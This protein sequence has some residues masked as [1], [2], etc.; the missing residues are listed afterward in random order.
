MLIDKLNTFG[1]PVALNTGA[2]GTYVI[3]D[4]INLGPSPV[5]QGVGIP[6]YWYIATA[7]AATSADSTATATFQ[8]VGADNA[9]LTTNPVVLMQTPAFIVTAMPANRFLFTAAIPFA[10]YKQFLG[11]RQVTGVQAITAGSIRSF[12]T[13]EP[14]QWRAYPEANS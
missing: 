7:V 14:D 2:A 3:G 1:L 12:L 10:Q 8:L 13:Q 6:Y 4:Q 11:I 9:A 5:N